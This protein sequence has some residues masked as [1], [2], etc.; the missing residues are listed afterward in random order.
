MERTKNRLSEVKE[1]LL[2]KKEL[3]L[4]AKQEQQKEIATSIDEHKTTIL[5][6]LNFSLEIPIEGESVIVKL[7]AWQGMQ[8]IVESL[9]TLQFFR[10]H[11]EYMLNFNTS[12]SLYLAKAIFVK[13]LQ[14]GNSLFYVVQIVAPLHLK[15]QR[16]YFRLETTLPIIININPD[17]VYDTQYDDAGQII[18]NPDIITVETL[19]IS[20]GGLKIITSEFFTP[21]II[22]S[23]KF[24]IQDIE[25]N[26]R[27]KILSF[28]E[29]CSTGKYIYRIA[30]IDVEFNLQEQLLQNILL[31]QREILFSHKQKRR[32]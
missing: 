22:V 16:N 23:T 11:N 13:K 15:R 24:I 14:K 25:Y 31:L 12:T 6:D 5:S 3:E 10:L 4:K 27:G 29:K 2:R 21:E 26:I 28:Y 1:I 30:F 19:D 7:T 18:P 17:I 32:K 20:A 9:S 8:L